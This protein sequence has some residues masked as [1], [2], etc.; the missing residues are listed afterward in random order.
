M[1]R[2][3]KTD[4]IASQGSGIT[5]AGDVTQDAGRDV[6][7]RDIVN[8]FWNLLNV[9]PNATEYWSGIVGERRAVEQRRRFAAKI[10]TE[11]RERLE[12]VRG[13]GNSYLRPKL[14]T[15][16]RAIPDPLSFLK[17]HQQ[18]SSVE[19][20]PDTSILEIYQQGQ[21]LLVLGEPGSGKTTLL[22]EL[23]VEI[24]SNKA[25]LPEQIPV[26][27]PLS[28]WER[29]DRKM[30]KG[31]PS[32]QLRRF[33]A[34]LLEEL[35][36]VPEGLGSNWLIDG[37]LILLL[38]GLDEI[39]L[40]NERASLTAAI[41]EYVSK[42]SPNVVLSCRLA[43][44]QA[45]GLQAKL[46]RAVV[47]QALEAS[48][49]L[50]FVKQQGAPYRGLTESLM[51][52]EEML[53][54]CTSPLFLG[55]LMYI[56]PLHSA[57]RPN[58]EGSE[59]NTKTWLLRAYVDERFNQAMLRGDPLPLPFV[60]R[61]AERSL[62]W[63]SWLA[64]NMAKQSQTE[65]LLERMQPNWLPKIGTLLV[66]LC[67]LLITLPL[68]LVLVTPNMPIYLLLPLVLW[69]PLF[70]LL[71][72]HPESQNLNWSLRSVLLRWRVIP[73]WVASGAII[74]LAITTF[75]VSPTITKFTIWPFGF[76]LE[77]YLAGPAIGAVFGGI[78]GILL[79]GF[80]AIVTESRRRPYESV[81][82]SLRIGCL[83]FLII[84]VA[85]FF[86]YLLIYKIAGTASIL[87]GSYIF[88]NFGSPGLNQALHDAFMFAFMFAF[89]FGWGFVSVHLVLRLWIWMLGLGPGRYVR[90][91]NAMVEL[92][93][94][95][96]S[97][98]GFVFMHRVL[99]EF[100]QSQEASH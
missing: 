39:A 19:I 48:D 9:S 97:G 21:S 93:L 43:E 31:P 79:V 78:S 62:K 88:L 100:F 5:T 56:Y 52:D 85:V 58:L 86:G 81:F 16:P 83:I 82:A 15:A 36:K 60:G 80:T 72:Y 50:E 49:V 71:V 28:T 25:D 46:E 91:L 57:D 69:Y 63:L 17:T 13:Q 24:L 76:E 10:R 30:R 29:R 32:K 1:P 64:Q 40:H 65:F 55:M 22:L 61:N 42:Y 14:I 44:Y 26:M 38:D 34:N 59:L 51:H 98:A 74:G 45:L 7:G 41:N 89:I 11:Y 12:Q 90:W 75:K 77:K 84:A 8:N 20:S 95:Y 47:I 53:K 99:Q 27:I 70:V 37:H 33:F 73:V 2:T 6:A 18:A 23:A 3:P 92:R 54:L 66:Q 67:V 94:M 87:S 68:G 35:Y 4:G 96:R